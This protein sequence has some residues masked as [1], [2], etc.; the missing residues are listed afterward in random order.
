[1]RKALAQRIRSEVPELDRAVDAVLRHWERAE[2]VPED[3]DAVLNSVALNLHGF[4][5]GVERVL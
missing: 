5:N 1:M 4:Y 2:V 3:R